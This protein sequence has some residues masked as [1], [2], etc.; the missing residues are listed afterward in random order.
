MHGSSSASWAENLPIWG[1]LLFQRPK[2]G[3]IGQPL[4]SKVQGVKTH[5]K[6]H[7]TDEHFVEYRAACGRRSACVDIGQSPLTYLISTHADRQGVDEWT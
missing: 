6:R 3:R 1:T 2:I 7:A 5:L 4:G